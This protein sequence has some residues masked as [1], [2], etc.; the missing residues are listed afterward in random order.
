VTEATLDEMGPV[1]YVVLEWPDD[2]PAAGEVQPLLLDLVDRG[3][4][5][6][7]GTATAAAAPPPAPA[8]PPAVDQTIQQLKD[9]A[10]LRDQGI[11]T[12][13]EFAA[14]KARILGA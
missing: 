8:P 6:V 14:Q 10:A 4:I 7:G 5:E 2:Q 11:L 13:E 12:E 3:I 9:L 1:D